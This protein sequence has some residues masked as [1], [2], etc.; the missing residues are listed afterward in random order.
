VQSSRRRH[1]RKQRAN[2]ED[3]LINNNLAGGCAGRTRYVLADN[4]NKLNLSEDTEHRAEDNHEEEEGS[5]DEWEKTRGEISRIW[6]PKISSPET[7]SRKTKKTGLTTKIPKP[8]LRSRVLRG[9]LRTALGFA[10]FFMLSLIRLNHVRGEMFG[11]ILSEKITPPFA[12]REVG[13]LQRFD[14]NTRAEKRIPNSA[15]RDER[16]RSSAL[17]RL[18]LLSCFVILFLLFFRGG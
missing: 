16:H 12:S 5:S 1:R 2:A 9:V 10:I 4:A 6:R 14:E 18:L 11:C 8:S 7:K 17:L 15:V 13:R 3:S